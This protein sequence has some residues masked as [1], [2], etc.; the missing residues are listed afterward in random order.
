MFLDKLSDKPAPKTTKLLLILGI[1][2]V[3]IF[4]GLMQYFE[5]FAN[6]PVSFIESQLSFSGA[7]IKAWFS[8]MS[9]EELRYYT[10]VQV[11]DYGFMAGFGLIIFDLTLIIARKFDEDSGWR[12]SGYIVAVLGILAACFDGI[13]NI[14][15]FLMLSDP[16]GFPDIWAIAHSC[17][18]LV[19]LIIYFL[20]FTLWTISAVIARLVKK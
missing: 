7:K 9:S 16:S 4:S 1:L 17:F 18:A 2:L 20:I 13:E 12:K 5:T 19:K 8:T 14:F 3:L 15:I 10:L 6:Y 11:L